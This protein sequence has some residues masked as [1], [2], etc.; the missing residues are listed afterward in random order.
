MSGDTVNKVPLSAVQEKS[1]SKDKETDEID[2]DGFDDSNF[3]VRGSEET[4]SIEIV[5]THPE[6]A[7]DTSI[8]ELRDQLRDLQKKDIQ[9]V[10]HEV[11][12]KKGRIAIENINIAES[13]DVRNLREVTIQGKFLP[14]PKHYTS[15]RPT[16]YEI[17]DSNIFTFLNTENT[18]SLDLSLDS[19]D[20]KLKGEKTGDVS[21]KISSAGSF[22]FDNTESG[23]IDI[24]RI[25]DSNLNLKNVNSGFLSS[26]LALNS[27][28]YSELDALGQAS[29]KRKT[30]SDVSSELDINEI[31][32]L[33]LSYKSSA[34]FVLD[35]TGIFSR[36]SSFDGQFSSSLDMGGYG[37]RYGSSYSNID[38]YLYIEKTL[39]KSQNYTLEKSGILDLEKLL[40]TTIYI[41]NKIVGDI[42]TK[43]SFR[44]KTIMAGGYGSTYGS[45]YGM[46]LADL[47]TKVSVS[48]RKTLKGSISGS[49]EILN[50][51]GYRYG[52][53]Y[54]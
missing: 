16:L 19:G 43:V 45:F 25:L 21:V 40:T 44:G 48:K 49:V 54:G 10:T 2:L 4:E 15:N 27:S 26:L 32:A 52:N 33:K 31:L 9:D 28:S 5:F 30:S 36:Q 42:S 24:L 1:T 35:S 17:L 8:S 22:T 14:W 41:K 46:P 47:S 51:Y 50:P 29:R 39:S 11:D 7:S 38:P 34:N 18:F 3:V 12:G 13:S 23:I 6:N 20:I 37:S 53:D